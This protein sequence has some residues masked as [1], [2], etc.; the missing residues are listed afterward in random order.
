M[1]LTEDTL[2]ILFETLYNLSDNFVTLL[3]GTSFKMNRMLS[4]FTFLGD[5]VVGSSGFNSIDY[6]SQ[7]NYLPVMQLHEIFFSAE[8]FIRQTWNLGRT[9][10]NMSSDFHYSKTAVSRKNVVYIGAYSTRA[11]LGL[12]NVHVRR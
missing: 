5:F 11:I 2:S 8:I 3:S 6:N 9:T 1:Q 7:P 10:N 12:L 4:V